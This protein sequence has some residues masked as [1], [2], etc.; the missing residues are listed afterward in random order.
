MSVLSKNTD[1]ILTIKQKCKN[2]AT[3]KAAKILNL[4]VT[5]QKNKYYPYLDIAYV[6][7]RGATDD[8]IKLFYHLRE[9]FK[10]EA[11]KKEFKKIYI[12]LAFY[13]GLSVGGVI[14]LACLIKPLKKETPLPQKPAVI[15]KAQPQ[16][17]TSST[18][19][20]KE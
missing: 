19:H 16:K 7:V 18:E 8:Q 11:Y 10:Q 17:N 12:R 15:Q 2:E 5:Y 6:D 9:T 3:K 1:D 4:P 13:T 14:A 20:V